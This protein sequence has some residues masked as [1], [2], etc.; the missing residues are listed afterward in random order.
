M[1]TFV[2]VDLDTPLTVA[3]K[4]TVA[5]VGAVPPVHVLLAT[6]PGV[7]VIVQDALTGN[8]PVDGHVLLVMLVP[9]GNPEDVTDTFCA[10][11]AVELV[12]V[13]CRGFPVKLGLV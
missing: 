13:I 3:V 6:G 7:I 8:A 1:K 5:G 4:V 11:N 2:V 10:G 12:M 9:V